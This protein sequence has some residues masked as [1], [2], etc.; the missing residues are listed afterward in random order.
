M[1]FAK[2]CVILQLLAI[3]HCHSLFG[4]GLSIERVAK[5]Y[6]NKN[7]TLE[8]LDQNQKVSKVFFLSVLLHYKKKCRAI[9]HWLYI[10]FS[11]YL[12]VVSTIH[13]DSV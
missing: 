5:A 2:G 10:A 3:L 1:V 13:Y 7:C 4:R 9:L 11:W 6:G 12:R 8:T